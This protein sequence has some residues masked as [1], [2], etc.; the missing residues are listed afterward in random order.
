MG[1]HT[2]RWVTVADDLAENPGT[3]KDQRDQGVLPVALLHGFTQTRRCW[4]PFGESL[5]IDRPLV[6]LDLPGHGSA[7]AEADLDCPEAARALVDRT[8]TA[9]WL[10][11]SLGGRIALHAALEHPGHVRSLVL[12]GATAGIRDTS[13]REDRRRLDE[14]RA[15]HLEA[16]GV[17]RF[18]REWLEMPM[19][20]ELPRWAQFEP[21]RA[22]N[23]V[24]GLA[25]SLR[26]AGT[27]SM[28]PLWEALGTLTMPVLCL[29]GA[30]DTRFAEHAERMAEAIGANASVTLIDGAGHAA[31]L[32]RPL[33]TC[34]AVGHFL[35]RCDRNIT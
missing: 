31:H 26:N 33:S 34:E 16:V 32:E 11:Y 15:L 7:T 10:G 28:V 22:S 2:L 24:H 19:F 13:E 5:G 29:A 20:A 3:P 21:E 6:A 1:P 17:P 35:D 8:G 27:G 14:E 12:I 4:G 23:T 30:R 9:D 25:M 18:C